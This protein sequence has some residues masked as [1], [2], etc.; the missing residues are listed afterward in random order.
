VGDVISEDDLDSFEGWIKHQGIE[1]SALSDTDREMWQSMYLDVQRRV[2][3]TPK[4][5]SMKLTDIPNE[6]R[7]AVAVEDNGL[8]LTLWIRRSK[9]GEI[10]VLLPRGD[11]EWDAHTSY[12]AD[13]TLHMKSHGMTFQTS[14]KQ[15]LTGSFRG[16]QSLGTYYG[17]GPKEVGAV[18]N[19]TS[20]DV[21]MRIPPGVLGPRHGGV[22]VDLVEPG[23]EL[24]SP[25][26][27]NYYRHVFK[28]VVPWISIAVGPSAQVA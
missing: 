28:D 14:K 3:E 11:K 12:H 10:F 1:A 23:V 22:Q 8:W 17:H 19:P 25:P 9:K 16:I 5:G 21:V 26:W 15:P 27:S 4:V 6:Y 18:C 13:G 24:L 20:F 7:L 2:S